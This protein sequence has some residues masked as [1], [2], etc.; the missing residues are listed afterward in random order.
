MDPCVAF[1]AGGAAFFM[2]GEEIYRIETDRKRMTVAGEMGSAVATQA[3][4]K[5]LDSRDE[6]FASLGGERLAYISRVE[7]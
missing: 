1:K 2:K 6:M 7:P 5:R 3:F 4:F